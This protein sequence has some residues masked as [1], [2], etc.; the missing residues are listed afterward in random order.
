MLT[1]Q[2][3]PSSCSRL[4]DDLALLIAPRSGRQRGVYDVARGRVGP[5]ACPASRRD[6]AR[7]T[8][9]PGLKPKQV[10]EILVA[11]RGQ[12]VPKSRLADLLWSESLPQNYLATL[13]T[14]VSVLRQVLEPGVRAK[15][16]VIVT[17]R[18]GYRLDVERTTV[19][20][21][22]FDRIVKSAAG[23]QP[24]AALEILNTALRLVRGPVLA[25]EPYSGWAEQLRAAYQQKHVQVLVDA[26]RL[27]LITGEA[28]AALAAGRGGRDAGPARR[29]RLPGADDRGVRAVAP[30]G[31][32]AGVRP[33]PAS[34]RRGARAS[35]RWT[36]R[37]PCTWRSCG[38]RTWPRSC[39]DRP[40]TRWRRRWRRRHRLPGAARAPPRAAAAGGRGQGPGWRGGSR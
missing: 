14:Y 31:R 29:G 19:D 21:E 3:G 10:L 20:L 39:R 27:S 15:D 37:W 18:G 13:E 8:D 34:A 23:Q 12:V 26:G 17:E 35:T 40:A 7:S 32:A 38:T 28:T 5:A 11:E 30:G 22:E 4:P 25:D 33:L 9:F 1:G 36:R 16:S 6:P 24:V 2:Y